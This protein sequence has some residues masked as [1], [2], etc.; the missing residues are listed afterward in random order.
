MMKM[1]K[2]HIFDTISLANNRIVEKMMKNIVS[3]RLILLFDEKKMTFIVVFSPFISPFF[4]H[5]FLHIE[6]KEKRKQF[7]QK[8]LLHR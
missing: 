2:F 3:Y 1:W 7:F 6:N 5:K 4:S 8:L